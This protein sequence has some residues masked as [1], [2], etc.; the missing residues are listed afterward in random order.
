ML[1]TQKHW[2]LP[3][4]HLVIFNFKPLQTNK[5]QWPQTDRTPILFQVAIFFDAS[6]PWHF[7]GKNQPMIFEGQYDPIH[8]PYFPPRFKLRVAD[9]KWQWTILKKRSWY[10]E[11]QTYGRGKFSAQVSITCLYLSILSDLCCLVAW[12]SACLALFIYLSSHMFKF[13]TRILTLQASWAL[14]P[15]IWNLLNPACQPKTW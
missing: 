9:W 1:T 11:C 5:Q 10:S 4:H 8:S 13:G 12:L 6:F 14:F 7:R 3:V 15:S 2:T